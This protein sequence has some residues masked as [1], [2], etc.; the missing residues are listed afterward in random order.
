MVDDALTDAP[1]LDELEIGI[2]GAGAEEVVPVPWSLLLQ[3]RVAGRLEHSPRRA[4]VVLAA[5]LL[6]MFATGFS[7]TVLAVSLGDIARALGTSKSM[8]TWVITGPSLAMAVLGPIG[9][10]LADRHGAR[11]VY[12]S[13]ISG[14]AFMSGLTIFAWSGASLV[15]ARV[16]GAMLGAAVSPAALAMI[17][18]S[19]PAERRA[20]ALGYWSLVGAGSPVIGVVIGGPLVEAYGWRWIFILQTPL[21]V[22][23]AII[24]FL[25]L[26]HTEPGDRHPFDVAGSVLLAGGVGG[27]LLALNR[28]PEIGWSSSFV[29]IGLLASVILL[30]A[31][32]VV[33]SRTPHPLLPMRYFRR[34]NFTFPMANQFFA[35]FAYMGGF[36]LT[37]LLMTE[38]LG[39]STT[40]A[41]LVSIARPLAF[42]IIGPISG[43]MVLRRGERQIGSFG[44][45]VLIVSMLLLSLVSATTSPLLLVA[46]LVLSG[47]G[48][49]SS[50][51]AMIAALANS[52]DRRDLG[53]A[54][55]AS[56]TIVQIGVVMG[57]QVL[58]TIQDSREAALGDASYAVAYRW[59]AAAA[60]VALVAASIVR[61]TT[62]DIRTTGLPAS[63]PL[64]A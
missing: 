39:Y 26:P 22:L 55:A 15:G 60:A 52:V 43:W 17:N 36:I 23:A 61:R 25:A 7:L 12:L 49:G 33:E 27:L 31:F 6:G 40:K 35:N 16:L 56:Q 38:M 63:E 58:L 34:R 18:R 51:P 29:V 42:S 24:G 64:G 21:A 59:G 47:I 10:K 8:L 28:A 46:A 37:P 20:Q 1:E 48:M 3:R 57:M 14:V 32:V 5:S 19:F 11:R 4:W 45:S 50:A 54:G 44:S 53:V 41:G 9:G 2:E 13:S 62:H 30:V